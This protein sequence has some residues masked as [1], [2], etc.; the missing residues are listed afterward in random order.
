VTWTAD[1]RT[2]DGKRERVVFRETLVAAE[3][4]CCRHHLTLVA[5]LALPDELKGAAVTGKATTWMFPR[6]QAGPA[7]GAL[8]PHRSPLFPM[9]EATHGSIQRPRASRAGAPPCMADGNGLSGR[10]P[11]AF[12]APSARSAHVQRGSK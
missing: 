5:D 4:A 2:K 3:S 9:R 10:A 1:W 11:V 8:T 7:A 6:H 12:A